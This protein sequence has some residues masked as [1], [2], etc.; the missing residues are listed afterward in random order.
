MPE[1]AAGEKVFPASPKKRMEARKKG[2]VVRS[3]DFTAAIVLLAMLIAIRVA[4]T[5]GIVFDELKADLYSYFLFMPHM[6][7]FD[8][9][10]V[11][12]L[13]LRAAQDVAILVAPPLLAAVVLALISNVAQVGLVV[14]GEGLI[15]DFNRVNPATGIKRLLSRRGGVE[16]LKGIC[17]FALVGWVCWRT[18]DSNKE[19]IVNALA[20]PFMKFLTNIGELCWTLGLHVCTALLILAAA[21]YG[22]QKYEYEQQMKMTRDE[23]KQ[24]MKN[25][26]G[27]PQIKQKIRQR[28]RAMSQKRMMEKVKKATV[29]V[30]NPTH[31]AVALLYEKEISAPIVV[32]RGAD[33][34]ALRIKEIAKEHR[35]PIVENKAIARALYNEVRLDRPIPPQL[36]KAVAEIIAFVY[37]TKR[38]A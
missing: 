12:E 28:Q 6:V 19:L 13:E 38:A 20:L 5:N 10:T 8:F 2:Q 9:R 31:F 23:M 37:R 1:Q 36:Y 30:T 15:P 24:E 18:V 4:V 33:L 7:V 27:D 32:A 16:L 3:V 21:D 34:V 11:R 35:V 14:S 22:Y 29:V 26:D 17:K 25:S